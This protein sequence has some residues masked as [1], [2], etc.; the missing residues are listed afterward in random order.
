MEKCIGQRLLK[1]GAPP[2]TRDG[3]NPSREVEKRLQEESEAREKGRGFS[4]W[5]AKDDLRGPGRSGG[6]EGGHG[7]GSLCAGELGG[8]DDPE[9]AVGQRRDSWRNLA[10]EGRGGRQDGVCSGRRVGQGLANST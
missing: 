3:G 6:R 8:K 5:R 2:R 9:Q 1:T 10:V 4:E 7:V